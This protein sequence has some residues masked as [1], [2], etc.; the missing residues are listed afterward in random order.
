MKE[1][2]AEK[3]IEKILNSSKEEFEIFFN[4]NYE[5][6]MSIIRKDKELLAKIFTKIFS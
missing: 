1:I 6:I 3:E 5:V 2:N 4:S